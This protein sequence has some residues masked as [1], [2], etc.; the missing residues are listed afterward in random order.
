MKKVLAV[1]A[2]CAALIGSVFAVENKLDL[3]VAIP[4]YGQKL[5]YGSGPETVTMSGFGFSFSGTTM[6]SDLIGLGAGLTFWKPATM[7]MG[8]VKIKLSD[9]G[10]DAGWAMDADIGLA[11]RPVNTNGFSLYVV[12]AVAYCIQFSQNNSVIAFGLDCSVQGTYMFTNNIGISA[13]TTAG[14]YL[15][16]MDIA[17]ASTGKFNEFFL[18]PKI[19]L[20]FK[21]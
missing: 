8:G 17:S 19:Y 7:K 6:Y 13:A 3:G 5:D 16:G 21:Y 11:I 10:M 20:T 4:T 1:V 9:Y 2:I 12:P 15:F 14:Y 18:E